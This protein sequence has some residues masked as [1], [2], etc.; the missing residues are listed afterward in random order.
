MVSENRR[1]VAAHASCKLGFIAETN[2]GL[3]HAL[4][5]RC[6]GLRHALTA[7]CKGLRHALAPPPFR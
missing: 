2:A 7:R 1:L 4:T 3:R 5:A 6:K